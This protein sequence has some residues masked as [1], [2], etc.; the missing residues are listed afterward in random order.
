MFPTAET[1]QQLYDAV[2]EANGI[3]QMDFDRRVT[4]L[5]ENHGIAVPVAINLLGA[6]LAEGTLNG[7]KPS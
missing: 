7:S 3:T 4:Y 1:T 6:M 2:L 5:A